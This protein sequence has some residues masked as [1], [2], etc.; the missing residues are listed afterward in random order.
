MFLTACGIILILNLFLYYPTPI[1]ESPMFVALTASLFMVSLNRTKAVH[2]IVWYS[3]PAW[4][5]MEKPAC[6]LVRLKI[7][8]TD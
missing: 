5:A 2:R 1:L 8:G 3:L 4:S 7:K 6:S